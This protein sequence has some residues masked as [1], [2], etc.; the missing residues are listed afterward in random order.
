MNTFAL[1]DCNSFYV[2]CER[3]FKPPVSTTP[4]KRIAYYFAI[5]TAVSEFS[6]IQVENR[7]PHL[8]SIYR[9]R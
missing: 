8:S 5:Y 4:L 2:S 1:V 3:V 9:I 6:W 7:T